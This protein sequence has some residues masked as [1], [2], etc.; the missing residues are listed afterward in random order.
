MI[1]TDAVP[2]AVDLLMVLG[3]RNCGYKIEKAL[4]TGR[5]NPGARYIVSGGFRL[6]E[7][8]GIT[9]SGKWRSLYLQN[10]QVCRYR[11]DP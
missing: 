9:L 7:R 5:R 10:G 4:E 11:S 1:Q 3:S 2:A 8:I 6:V